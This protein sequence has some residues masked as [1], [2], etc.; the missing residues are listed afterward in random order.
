ME[1]VTICR[2]F[3]RIEW[4][5]IR[6]GDRDNPPASEDVRRNFDEIERLAEDPSIPNDPRWHN[7]P[8][9]LE[10]DPYGWERDLQLWKAM[11]TIP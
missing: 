11:G 5:K 2:A 7:V 4:R 9:T 8:A 10:D 6:D 1:E 3:G